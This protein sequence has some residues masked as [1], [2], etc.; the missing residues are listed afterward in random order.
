MALLVHSMI[1]LLFFSL[2]FPPGVL[3]DTALVFSTGLSFSFAIAIVFLYVFAHRGSGSV[4]PLNPLDGG[5][6]SDYL[7]LWIWQYLQH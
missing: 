3:D 6:D 1:Y 2:L 4:H 5:P 7:A